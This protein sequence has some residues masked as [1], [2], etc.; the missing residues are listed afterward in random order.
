MRNQTWLISVFCLFLLS[1]CQNTSE[2][3]R[4]KIDLLSKEGGFNGIAYIEY[5]GEVL[6]QDALLNPQSRVDVPGPDS[7]LYLASLSKIFTKVC[8]ARMIASGQ[9]HPDSTIF[10][11]RKNMQATF[12]KQ[13]NIGQ[14]ISMTS[15]LPRELNDADVFGSLKLDS[16][17]MAGPFLDKLPE[18]ELSFEPGSGYAYSNLNYWLLGAVMEAVSGKDMNRLLSEL[19]FTPL[20]MSASGYL[21]SSFFTADQAYLHRYASGG[22]FSSLNDLKK[23]IHTLNGNLFLGEEAKQW[24][25]G[26]EAQRLEVYG[27]LPSVTHML[28]WDKEAD[29]CMI[30]LN[31]VGLENPD[32][33]L[34]FKAE[35]CKTLGI[36]PS[37]QKEKSK[38]ILEPVQALSDSIPLEAAMKEWVDAIQKAEPESIFQ[39]IEKQGKVNAF[40]ADDPT[41]ADIAELRSKL[42]GFHPAGYRWIEGG[43]IHGLEVWFTSDEEAKIGF[44]W[45]PDESDPTKIANL[46]V[47]PVDMNW[48]GKSY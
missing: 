42:P 38:I 23:L 24:I 43:P 37:P 7:S 27:A 48:Q 5:Q 9:L 4:K 29:F 15:G 35:V 20:D 26:K 1:G 32:Y 16:Q 17:M 30:V 31:N 41:W 39:D 18:Q 12:A 21:S 45:I 14:L 3:L 25:W 10:S 11:Y 36:A 28:L 44:L 34:K 40:Q 2:K 22:F 6:F 19:I 47:K 8:A 13:I 46:M 33:M